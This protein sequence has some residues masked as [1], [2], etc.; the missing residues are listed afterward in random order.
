MV[1]DGTTPTAPCITSI[2]RDYNAAVDLIERNLKT[3]RGSKIAYI[4][5]R[6]RYSYSELA[7]R[8]DRAA[9]AFREA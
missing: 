2:P 8:V 6:R 5:D 7:E 3:G 4:D 1:A 9:N